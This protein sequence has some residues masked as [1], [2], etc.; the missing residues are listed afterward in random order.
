[1]EEK[2]NNSIY[3]TKVNIDMSQCGPNSKLKYVEFS[4][5]LQN[6]AAKHS[7]LWNMSFKDMQKHQQAWVSS[8]MRFEFEELPKWHQEVEIATWIESI[9]GMRSIRNFE[10][11]QNGKRMAGATSLWVVFNTEKR[12]PDNLAIPYDDLILYPEKKSTKKSVD[13]V[14]IT[15]KTEKISSYTVQYSDLDIVNHANNIKY[16]EWCLN[17]LDR[18]LLDNESISALE[19][20]FMR[21]LTWNDCVDIE[22]FKED[23]NIYFYIKKEQVTIF[24]LKIELK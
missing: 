4:N 6:I 21:E 15:K 19:M 20:N 10:M 7:S 9:D 13:F 14:D 23:K 24:A 5:I 18:K 11:L 12:R 17:L 3:Q 16:T 2:N 1:M 8:R 22:Q